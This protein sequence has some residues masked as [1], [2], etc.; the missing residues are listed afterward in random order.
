MKYSY[1]QTIKIITLAALLS[2]GISFVSAWAGPQGIPPESNTPTPV[3]VSESGQIKEGGLLVGNLSTITTGLIV[4]YG[5]VGLGV[6][7][8]TAKLDVAGDVKTS[9]NLTVTGSIQA[10]GGTPI[11]N[12]PLVATDVQYGDTSLGC[13]GALSLN[14]TCTTK[15]CSYGKLASCTSK[16]HTCTLVGRLVAP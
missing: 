8:P 11:Y 16:T 10:S 5:N 3:N 4:R 9:G 7:S 15:S 12:C 14:S 1:F 13:T 6:T 2:L